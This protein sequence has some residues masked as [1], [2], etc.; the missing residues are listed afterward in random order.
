MF[1][2]FTCFGEGIRWLVGLPLD[3]LLWCGIINQR[4]EQKIRANYV[5]KLIN[6][7]IVLLGVV[8]SIITI[9]LGWEDML[10]IIPPAG[11]SLYSRKLAILA[12]L[13]KSAP[14]TEKSLQIML[15][16]VF[17]AGLI[18]VSVIYDKYAL[19]LDLET[20]L[21]LSQSDYIRRFVR[22]IIPANMGIFVSNTKKVVSNIYFGG[23]LKVAKIISIAAN[24]NLDGVDL[25]LLENHAGRV[26]ILKYMEV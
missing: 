24:N 2:P 14:Y 4:R 8:S 5:Y 20:N 6:N 19:Y 26:S 21:L 1:N 13:N 3:I 16:G 9:A 10:K 23:A 17:G 7:F 22:E 25:S 15:D 12:K 11:A 18:D